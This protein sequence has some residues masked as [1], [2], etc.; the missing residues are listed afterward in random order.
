MI[1]LTPERYAVLVVAEDKYYRLCEMLRERRFRG[2]SGEEVRLIQAV[3][4]TEE[5]AEVE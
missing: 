1:E 5:E 3:M 2:L 4:G